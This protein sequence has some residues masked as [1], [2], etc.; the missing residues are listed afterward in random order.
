MSKRQDVTSRQVPMLRRGRRVVGAIAMALMLGAS[1]FAGPAYGMMDGDGYGRSSGSSYYIDVLAP[2]RYTFKAV[3]Y[4]LK[5]PYYALKVP[6]YILRVPAQLL[7]KD[8]YAD[9]GAPHAAPPPAPR[10]GYGRPHDPR[11]R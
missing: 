2:F 3:K 4:A 7:Q 8:G 9:A 5:V 6:I 10:G 1:G 11:V